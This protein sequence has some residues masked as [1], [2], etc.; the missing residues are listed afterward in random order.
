MPTAAVPDYVMPDPVSAPCN[1]HQRPSA[2]PQIHLPRTQPHS[3]E[4]LPAD[5]P[6]L[7]PGQIQNQSGRTMRREG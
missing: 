2:D 5:N 4:L 7:S 1:R 6:L 3:K